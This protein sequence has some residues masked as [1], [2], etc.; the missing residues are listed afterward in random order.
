MPAKKAEKVRVEN[1]V[2]PGKTYTVDAAKYRA[3]RRA[4]LKVLPKRAPGLTA[5]QIVR[6]VA[7]MLPREL[8]QGSKAGWWAKVVQLDLEAKGLV[9][10]EKT[11][12]LRFHRA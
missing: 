8:R 7:R 9:V 3:T 5:V 10:R 2:Q 6:R 4:F 1:V 11:S 12:P